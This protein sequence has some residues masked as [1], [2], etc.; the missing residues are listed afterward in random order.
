MN[1][2]EDRF[3]SPDADNGNGTANAELQTDDVDGDAEAD[4]QAYATRD[5]T[6][7][8]G[9][10]ATDGGRT[11]SVSPFER[12]ADDDLD[13]DNRVRQLV[14]LWLIAPAR[15]L[16][17]D[18]RARIGSL[19]ILLFIVVGTVGPLLITYPEPNTGPRLLQPFQ[20]LE[21]VLGTDPK[22]QDIFK[23]IVHATPVMLKMILGGAVFSIILAT[24]VGI[25]A[26]YKSGW[27]ETVLMTVTDIMMTI[28]GLPLIIVVAAIVQP[29]S[30]I[31]VGILVS[32]NAWAGLARAI[33]SQVLTVRNASYVEASRTMGLGTPT[34]LGRDILPNLMP[35]VLVNFVGAARNVIFGSVGL[36]FLGVLPFSN[37]NWGVMITRAYNSGALYSDTIR[38]WL[39]APLF[40]IVLLSFGFILFAQGCDRLFNP[41]VRAR[42]ASTIDDPEDDERATESATVATVNQP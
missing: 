34:I 3:N 17:A 14:D 9:S 30:P 10:L 42:H 25:V 22:A 32:I 41:R 6:D 28:P 27:V 11:K 8:R 31:V 16:W 20:N 5:G 2:S 7:P 37:L 35:Y 18:W 40:T 21:F 39:L 36:Y 23:S 4:F 38:H 1:P 29:E 12:V 19:I 26:G 15:I 24:V 33:R 13:S